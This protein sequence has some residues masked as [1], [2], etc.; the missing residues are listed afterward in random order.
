MK[1]GCTVEQNEKAACLH[2]KLGFPYHASIIIGFLGETVEDLEMTVRWLE[3]VRPPIVGINTYVPLP[4][5]E[6]YHKLKMT[7]RIKVEDPRIWRMIGEV[8]NPNAPNFSDVPSTIL[9]RYFNEMKALA[10]N[11]RREA[12]NS[13]IWRET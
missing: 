3:R 1:K 4:G 9:L 8:N 11:L 5:C 12:Q 10:E 7:G 13:Q 6:D 2:A